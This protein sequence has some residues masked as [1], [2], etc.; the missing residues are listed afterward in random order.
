MIIVTVTLLKYYLKIYYYLISGNTIAIKLH[1]EK[2][3]LDST[4][5][6]INFRYR[7]VDNGIPKV[8]GKFVDKSRFV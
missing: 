1:S 2:S 8:P 5:T 4:Y 6:G 7:Q 3:A